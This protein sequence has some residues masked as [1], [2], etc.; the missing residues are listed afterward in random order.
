MA[1][2]H[3]GLRCEDDRGRHED[4][5]VTSPRRA[6]PRAALFFPRLLNA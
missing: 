6:R 4:G 3:D 5:E 2:A 1:Y